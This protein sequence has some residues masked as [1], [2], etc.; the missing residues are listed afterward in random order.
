MSAAEGETRGQKLQQPRALLEPRHPPPDEA[1]NAE[2][3]VEVMV[4]A[5]VMS[6]SSIDSRE[7]RFEA[8]MWL[9]LE[10]FVR[11]P[12]ESPAATTWRPE[13]TVLNLSRACR[14]CCGACVSACSG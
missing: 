13:L 4:R 6:L 12:I 1:L 8:L 11:L 5:H 9:Q 2:G 3:A 14:C 10:W 7:Q